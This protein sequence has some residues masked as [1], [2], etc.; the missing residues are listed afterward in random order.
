VNHRDHE[1]TAGVLDRLLNACG[2]AA[3]VCYTAAIVIAGA[4]HPNYS[5]LSQPISVLA[6]R[7]SPYRTFMTWFGM[8][9]T[10]ALTIFFAVAVIRRGISSWAA[11]GCGVL[12]MLLGLGRFSAGLFPCDP[13]CATVDT[14]SARLH[15]MAATVAMAGGSLSPL[16]MAFDPWW[17]R[18]EGLFYAS[19]GLGLGALATAAVFRLSAGVPSLNPFLGLF[20]R[21]TVGMNFA[22][23][24]LLAVT[25]RNRGRIQGSSLDSSVDSSPPGGCGSTPEAF[26]P[27]GSPRS[28]FPPS[29]VD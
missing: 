2:V 29:P 16:V 28:W 14:V 18:Q 25:Y 10:G 5:H 3:P 24:I 12:L 23:M 6:A 20:Q 13:G 1:A 19:L 26:L 27:A 7:E 8:F 17:R 11:I 9:P 22:W 4:L 15:L 21:L